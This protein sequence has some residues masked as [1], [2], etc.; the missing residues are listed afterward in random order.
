M[1]TIVKKIRLFLLSNF[2]N[3]ELN[4]KD[5]T[6]GQQCAQTTYINEYTTATTNEDHGVNDEENNRVNVE[7]LGL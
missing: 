2:R 5:M 7:G 6:Q 3:C 1:T 4:T